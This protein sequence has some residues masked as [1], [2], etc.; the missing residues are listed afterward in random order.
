MASSHPYLP[1]WHQMHTLPRQ[2]PRRANGVPHPSPPPLLQACPAGSGKRGLAATCRVPKLRDS[3]GESLPWTPPSAGE[4]SRRGV[5]CSPALSH[6]NDR[7]P[8]LEGLP[9]PPGGGATV[10]DGGAYPNVTPTLPQK[11]PNVVPTLL[12]C[13]PPFFPLY[14]E[15][16]GDTKWEPALSAV[17]GGVS[18]ECA[19]HLSCHCEPRYFGRRGG[20]PGGWYTCHRR[21]RVYQSD[22]KS[23]PKSY[24]N[25]TNIAP[26]LPGPRHRRR[27]NCPNLTYLGG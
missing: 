9:L 4:R 12:R 7:T 26:T 5:R 22:S 6:G 3:G 1:P 8:W 21:G 13:P 23:V 19:P 16:G 25:D 14:L 15:R 11:Y 18:V 10:I 20:T 17:E 24:Q 27:Q 2:A